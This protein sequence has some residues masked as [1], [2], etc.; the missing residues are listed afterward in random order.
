MTQPTAYKAQLSELYKTY[1]GKELEQAIGVSTRSIQNYLKEEKP[2]IPGPE[3]V[4]KI[5][6]AYAK[7]QK[8]GVIINKESTP[9]EVD[10]RDEYI[11]LL[12]KTIQEKE[13]SL[14]RLELNLNQMKIDMDLLAARI[15]EGQKEV[16]QQ[17]SEVLE[18]KLKPS[19]SAH[20]KQRG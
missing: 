4:R 3:V 1:T 19:H 14:H 2:S 17:V 9:T 7:H 13:N 15:L 8:E 6:E 20:S 12:K 11:A 16:V 10:Y 5:H 18:A